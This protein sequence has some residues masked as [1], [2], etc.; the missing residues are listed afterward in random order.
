MEDKDTLI[1]NTLT[2]RQHRAIV[3]LLQNVTVTGA[4]QESGIPESTLY[5]W[6]REPTFKSEFR[7]QRRMLYERAV[8]LA[9]R[10]STAAMAE[11]IEIMRSGENEYARLAAAKVVLEF[12]RE[13]DIEQRVAEIEE[14]LDNPASPSPSPTTVSQLRSVS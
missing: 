8:G 5:R 6:L 9:Q 7:K 12:A 13:T 10:A 14:M 3:A 2:T 1:S 4:S 11:V